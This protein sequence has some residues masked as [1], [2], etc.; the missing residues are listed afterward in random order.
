MRCQGRL[1][2]LY[3]DRLD[4]R[5]DLETYDRKAEENREQEAQLRLKIDEVQAAAARDAADRVDL[6]ML[7]KEV[8]NLF[9]NQ[10]E[11]EER[12][13]LQV[14]LQEA[15]WKAGVLQMSLREPFATLC[16]PRWTARH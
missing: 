14:L 4:G 7:V 11:A 13:M 6:A 9:Q 12:K 15:S 5:I 16:N 3:E 8:G 10:S 2:L 1:N